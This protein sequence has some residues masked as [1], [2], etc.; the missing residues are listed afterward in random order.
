VKDVERLDA[1]MR[2]VLALPPD[3]DVSTAAYRITETWDSVAHLQLLL[4]LE[5]HF[6]LRVED[7]PPTLA[8]YASIRRAVQGTAS[9]GT[10]RGTRA[11][12]PSDEMAPAA[13]P[14]AET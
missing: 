5:E 7:G 12:A 11:G 13:R 8:D 6:G 2:R 14:R 4:A 10:W 9:R 3:A 1:L